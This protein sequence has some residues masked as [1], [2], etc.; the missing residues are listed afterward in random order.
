MAVHNR[1][2]EVQAASSRIPQRHASGSPLT[3]ILQTGERLLQSTGIWKYKPTQE[4]KEAIDKLRTVLDSID[5]LV[6]AESKEDH[7]IRPTFAVTPHITVKSYVGQDAQ[8]NEQIFYEG[9]PTKK[10]IHTAEIIK[11][12]NE[13]NGND[14]LSFQDARGHT[15]KIDI[16]EDTNSLTFSREGKDVTFVPSLR[17]DHHRKF[18]TLDEIALGLQKE[19]SSL[20]KEEQKPN[21]D[22]NATKSTTGN[23]QI[24]PLQT[25][26]NPLRPLLAKIYHESLD[27]F[28]FNKSENARDVVHR[29]LE[30]LLPGMHPAVIRDI[31]HAFTPNPD[32]SEYR[33]LYL[34]RESDTKVK[35]TPSTKRS[36]EF[37]R[38]YADVLYTMLNQG[39]LAEISRNLT[40]LTYATNT[41]TGKHSTGTQEQ[42]DLFHSLIQEGFDEKQPIET[43]ILQNANARTSIIRARQLLYH[44]GLEA[45]TESKRYEAAINIAQQALMEYQESD[46]LDALYSKNP[47]NAT[48]TTLH[49]KFERID[50]LI[51]AMMGTADELETIRQE[52]RKD[53][54]SEDSA[55]H[56]KASMHLEGKKIKM[57]DDNEATLIELVRDEQNQVTDYHGIVRELA[58]T[59][60]SLFFET[61]YNPHEIFKLTSEFLDHVFVYHIDKIK[62]EEGAVTAITKK[63]NELKSLEDTT[64]FDIETAYEKLGEYMTLI[65][66]NRPSYK[67]GGNSPFEGFGTELTRVSD[68]VKKIKELATQ[69]NFDYANNHDFDEARDVVLSAVYGN[70]FMQAF[71]KKI[72]DYVKA[73]RD[74]DA[75]ISEFTEELRSQVEIIRKAQQDTHGQHATFMGIRGVNDRLRRLGHVL[76]PAQDAS[77]EVVRVYEHDHYAA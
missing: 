47:D 21:D 41:H 7:Y 64:H 69:D 34:R 11:Q 43:T 3:Q 2:A 15:I 28:G 35:T 40:T 4:D 16:D 32:N 67:E 24:I 18:K 10:A 73:K 13:N 59:S 20:G 33:V 71:D 63:Q 6:G 19:E 37:L 25:Y 60:R 70:K 46:F 77:P 30:F 58:D 75:T 1:R 48:H 14:K 39:E 22:E 9:I 36:R 74:I 29:Q 66:E 68:S 62:E 5:H 55:Y 42:I 61:F 17:E 27:A 49:K 76:R 65:E 52:L 51:S 53:G 56:V 38:E 72:P 31:Q 50:T 45:S 8:G 54:S 23:T 26:R 57:P 12:Y 44:S